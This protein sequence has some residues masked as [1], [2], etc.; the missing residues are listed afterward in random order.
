MEKKSISVEIGSSLFASLI[1][2]TVCSPLDVLRIRL[3]VQV[4]G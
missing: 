2:V 1:G 4:K 3:M